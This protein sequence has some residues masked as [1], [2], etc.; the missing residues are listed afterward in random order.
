MT[1]YIAKRLVQ[2]FLLFLVFMFLTFFILQ[3]LPGNAIINKLIGNP[4]LPPEAIELA[5]ER[6]GLD[7]HPLIQFRD[8]AFNFFQ[9]DLGFSYWYYPRPVTELI[10]ERL[11]RTLVLFTTALLVTYWAGFITGKYLAWRRNSR[12]AKRW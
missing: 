1:R 11:P 5:T 4:N 8:Y 6:L 12:A 9:G 3:A 2:M 10:A 7:K